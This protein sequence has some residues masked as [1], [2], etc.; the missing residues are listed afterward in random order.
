MLTP[1]SN[2]GGFTINNP[3]HVT[4]EQ[5][6][7]DLGRKIKRSVKDAKQAYSKA[8]KAHRKAEKDHS[9]SDRLQA[10]AV[11]ARHRIRDAK[12]MTDKAQ[13]EIK[14]V[15][16]SQERVIKWAA[17]VEREGRDVRDYADGVRERGRNVGKDLVFCDHRF[18]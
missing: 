2:L 8:R 1:R 5:D 3:L 17:C 16:A 9:K 7:A 10:A 13:R 18:Q 12:H 6:K 4:I 11:Q 15:N 14:E